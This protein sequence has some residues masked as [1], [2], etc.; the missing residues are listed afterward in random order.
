MSLECG[1]RPEYPENTHAGTGRTCKFHPGRASN[2]SCDCQPSTGLYKETSSSALRQTAAKMAFAFHSLL[3]FCVF[4]GLLHGVWSFSF[5][6]WKKDTAINNCPTGWTQFNCNCY[7]FQAEERDFD[8]AQ[9]VCEILGG[10][11]VSIHSPLE[12]I[13]VQG[14]LPID[15]IEAWIGYNDRMTPNTFEWT[16]GSA[17]DFDN[18]PNPQPGVENCVIIDEDDGLWDETDCTDEEAYV[19]I[20]PVDPNH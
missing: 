11:L 20:K 1:R 17:D 13:F 18:F 5:D 6:F 4:S 12:N 16:D 19:C 10:N 3:L 15:D 7:I 14:L 9:A 2:P 8:D